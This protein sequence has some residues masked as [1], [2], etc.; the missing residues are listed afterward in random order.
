MSTHNCVLII[1][2]NVDILYQKTFEH[3]NNKKFIFAASEENKSLRTIEQIYEFFYHFE[4]DRSTYVIVVGGGITTDTG[5][6]AASTWKRGCKLVL[7]PTTAMAMV[8]AAIGGKTAI[9]FKNT[10]NLIG[11]FY[12]P[13]SII[14]DQNFLNTLPENIKNMAFAEII[15]HAIGF[16][17]KYFHQLFNN[18]LHRHNRYGIKLNLENIRHSIKIKLN[19]VRQDPLEKYHR[20]LLNIGHTI[21]H[22]IESAYHLP[23]GT[24]VS[25]GL[26][27]ELKTFAQLGLLRN[28]HIIDMLQNIY[29]YFNFFN[30]I[31]IK[32]DDIFPYIIHD[33]KKNHRTITIPVITD[34]GKAELCDIVT[35]DFF[36]ALKIVVHETFKN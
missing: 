9:N 14:I 10:K 18:A 23:H 1:D 33:K 22:A 30:H 8:D 17:S 4:V 12:Q 24:A 20:K 28:I 3:F 19:I 6:F 36:E 35:N 16:D 5:A 31:H 7:V 15:K 34:I 26:L 29:Y 2:K 32:Y 25:I 21:G 11:T 13:E 27:L